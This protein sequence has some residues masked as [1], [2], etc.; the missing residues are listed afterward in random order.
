MNYLDDYI[1][2][3][4]SVLDALYLEAHKDATNAALSMAYR[5][6]A[7]RTASVAQ[8][9]ITRLKNIHDER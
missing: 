4:L 5:S 9:A 1:R 7:S 8:T 3:A 6:R 2:N